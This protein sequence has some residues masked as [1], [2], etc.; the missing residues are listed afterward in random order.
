MLLPSA[1]RFLPWCTMDAS[2]Y[3]GAVWLT[4]FANTLADCSNRSYFVAK[5]RRE[6][7]R[8][9]FRGPTNTEYRGWYF[10]HFFRISPVHPYAHNHSRERHRILPMHT[11]RAL[12]WL[13]ISTILLLH[14]SWKEGTAFGRLS[15]LF[16]FCSLP[17]AY[18]IVYIIRRTP[19]FIVL[20]VAA[21]ASHRV[22]PKRDGVTSH[23]NGTLSRIPE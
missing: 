2:K 6:Q 1:T 20:K 22:H 19:F 18:T 7:Y 5:V 15:C 4:F 21:V 10:D 8:V 16:F 3:S 9:F 17:A 12:P 14:M 23:V 13:I 11:S